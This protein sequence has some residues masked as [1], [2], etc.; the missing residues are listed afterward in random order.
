MGWQSEWFFCRSFL[1]PLIW[2]QLRDDLTAFGGCKIASLA[3]LV[4][5]LAVSRGT[6]IPLGL[7]TQHEVSVFHDYESGSCKA[8]YVAKSQRFQTCVLPPA[9]IQSCG[10][11]RSSSWWEEWQFTL[12]RGLESGIRDSLEP[13]LQWSAT[14]VVYEDCSPNFTFSS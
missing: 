1:K 7:P 10:E 11:Q 9:Q 8:S 4:M 14:A 6:S 2:L 5:V 12:Q 3:C 13:L